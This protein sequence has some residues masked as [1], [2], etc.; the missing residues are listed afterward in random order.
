[1][2]LFKDISFWCIVLAIVVVMVVHHLLSKASLIEGN[3][4]GDGT[5]IQVNDDSSPS[6]IDLE[7]IMR[8]SPIGTQ[9]DSTLTGSV[10]GA[11]KETIPVISNVESLRDQVDLLRNAGGDMSDPTEPCDA[12]C[13]ETRAAL[14]DAEERLAEAE[15]EAERRRAEAEIVVN[16]S[17]NFPLPE[18]INSPDYSAAS[19]GTVNC[20]DKMFL[21][22]ADT[23]RHEGHSNDW[24]NS[25]IDKI[26]DDGRKIQDYISRG[27]DIPCGDYYYYKPHTPGQSG[28]TT[29][30][31][32]DALGD[33]DSPCVNEAKSGFYTLEHVPGATD[34]TNQHC[35]NRTVRVNAPNI[36]NYTCMEQ[37]VRPITQ[38]QNEMVVEI[39]ETGIDPFENISE[40][41][42]NADDVLREA[43]ASSALAVDE[44]VDD[45]LVIRE[46]N[47]LEKCDLPGSD[48]S[49]TRGQKNRVNGYFDVTCKGV[50]ND[51]CRFVESAGYEK[52][53]LSCISPHNGC[54]EFP[55]EGSIFGRAE[56]DLSSEITDPV[57]G[58]DTLENKRKALR[59]Y[60]RNECQLNKRC[61]SSSNLP[62]TADS[63]AP[64][65]GGHPNYAR[66]FFNAS[67]REDGSKN[68]YCR[69]VGDPHGEGPNKLWLSCVSPKSP[70]EIKADGTIGPKGCDNK[71]PGKNEP[72][73]WDLD[74]I[75]SDAKR[76][77][78]VGDEI[79]SDGDGVPGVGG[80]GSAGAAAKAALDGFFTELCSREP[81]QGNNFITSCASLNDSEACGNSVEHVGDGHYKQCE[82]LDGK[83]AAQ[84]N[85][86]NMGLL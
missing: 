72:F 25:A 27:E 17:V 51:Y 66:G 5:Q 30:C 41:Y 47:H 80:A 85:K 43:Y 35:S 40:G 67:C 20:S 28:W 31:A 7:I 86:C 55:L 13:Q 75:D 32:N 2:K 62:D 22:V 74:D 34:G 14:A 18:E 15:A 16:S 50:E 63:D 84:E 52:P 70:A 69:F 49:A 59:N 81:C 6:S 82:I 56:E 33:G 38:E 54:Q 29:E 58:K 12:T 73:G 19:G 45:T 23:E 71:F 11:G 65:S 68:D 42:A 61:T 9:A 39:L 3:T 83:C 60:F 24:G 53:W 44:T 57:S 79:I 37:G 46:G 78:E 10:T 48:D 8:D 1:M 76:P 36:S 4:D 77:F 26:S 64:G 21:G